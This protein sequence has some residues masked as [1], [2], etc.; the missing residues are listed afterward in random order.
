MKV[1]LLEVEQ[2][3]LIALNMKENVLHGNGEDRCVFLDRPE[4]IDLYDALHVFLYAGENE[5][6]ELL[7]KKGVI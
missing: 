7:N 6:I 5:A 4:A 1:K 3:Q 2:G